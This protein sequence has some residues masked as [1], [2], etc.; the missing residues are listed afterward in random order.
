LDKL[1]HNKMPSTKNIRYLLTHIILEKPQK[2]ITT[3]NP[4]DKIKAHVP[5]MCRRPAAITINV[6]KFTAVKNHRTPRICLPSKKIS[7]LIIANK[8]TPTNNAIAQ[9]S[10]PTSPKNATNSAPVAKPAPIT[11]LITSKIKLIILIFPYKNSHQVQIASGLF[12]VLKVI[13]NQPHNH[14]R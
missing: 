13:I 3:Q 8:H 14:R 2:I 4:S 11:A 7:T 5:A 6:A 1:A 10:S 12:G 9:A